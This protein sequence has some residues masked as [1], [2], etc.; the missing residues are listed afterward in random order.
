[1]KHGRTNW[2]EGWWL[3]QPARVFGSEVILP[4]AS[5]IFSPR[6]LHQHIFGL[7]T[8]LDTHCP[9]LTFWCLRILNLFFCTESW[10]IETSVCLVT[11]QKYHMHSTFSLE[12]LCQDLWIFQVWG[13]STLDSYPIYFHYYLIQQVVNSLVNSECLW[14]QLKAVRVRTSAGNS[15]YQIA[16]WRVHILSGISVLSLAHDFVCKAN[17]L[18]F[19]NDQV[20]C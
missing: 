11:S 15:G 20:R 14:W 2:G 13:F 16:F 8:S 3:N 4:V 19:C 6:F 18:I 10:F 1:M 17:S 9:Q 12:L 5:S 7:A